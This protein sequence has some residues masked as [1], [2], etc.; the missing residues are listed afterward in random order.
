MR[1]YN[2]ILQDVNSGKDVDPKE[3]KM[4]LL[5]ADNQLV[6]SNLD[7]LKCLDS[8]YDRKLLEG[9]IG[10]NR[11]TRN[12]HKQIDIDKALEINNL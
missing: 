12:L 5:L 10:K 6:L 9:E 4:A 2:N 7:I 8:H 1:S 3:L 11:N